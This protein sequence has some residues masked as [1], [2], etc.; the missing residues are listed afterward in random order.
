[1][2]S[3]RT[4]RPYELI[5]FGA[6]GNVGVVISEYLEKSS[7]AKRWAI[8]GRNA[9]KLGALR[10]KIAD[11]KEATCDIVL[12]DCT[13]RDSMKKMASQ[14]KVVLTAAGP[15]HLY[16]EPVIQACIDAGTN[17]VDITGEVGWVYQMKLKYEKQAREKGVCISSFCGYDCIPPELSLGLANEALGSGDKLQS[18]ETLIEAKNMEGTGF[19]RGTALTFFGFIRDPVF[20]ARNLIDSVA[21]VPRRERCAALTSFFLWLLPCWSSVTEGFTLPNFMGLINVFVVHASAD[22]LGFGGVRFYDRLPLPQMPLNALSSLV[23]VGMFYS[24][25]AVFMPIL[26]IASLLAGDKIQEW[27][28]ARSI[29]G[30]PKAVTDFSLSGYGASGRKVSVNLVIPGD[31]GVC[32]TALLAVETAL[33]F[34]SGEKT[35]AGFLT[36]VVGLGSVYLAKRLKRAGVQVKVTVDGKS[37]IDGI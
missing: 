15:Y 22:A 17:Y 20:F 37:V 31:P 29:S 11:G 34:A 24:F 36:P 12:A 27:L 21:Y 28:E 25:M 14:T 16:G 10:T 26:V 4:E 3:E 9:K 1:M 19:P 5:V 6:T 30:V 8:A 32:C 33:G 18:A 35:T 23:V 2:P 7:D 13:D